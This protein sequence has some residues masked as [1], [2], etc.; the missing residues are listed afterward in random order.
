MAQ[1]QGCH[2]HTI[3]KFPDFFPDLSPFFPDQSNK[4]I[5]SHVCI[6]MII[7]HDNHHVNACICFKYQ[8][9]VKN[10]KFRMKCVEKYDASTEGVSKTFLNMLL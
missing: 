2:S 6:S 3:S 5:L 10:G 8:I 9:F 1:S 4:Q 7:Y